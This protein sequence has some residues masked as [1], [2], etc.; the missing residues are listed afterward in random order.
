M[1]REVEVA[2]AVGRRWR[3]MREAAAKVALARMA[4]K[5]AATMAVSR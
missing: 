5:V 3:A 1:G 4:V 2:M